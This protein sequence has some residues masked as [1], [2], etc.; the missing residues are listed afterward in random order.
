M[1][2]TLTNLNLSS[3]G[4]SASASNFFCGLARLT[5]MYSFGDNI[6]HVCKL[7]IPFDMFRI[8]TNKSIWCH[9]VI[10][11]KMPNNIVSWSRTM[12]RKTC[13]SDETS[14]A[15][16][17]VISCASILG[18]VG[19]SDRDAVTDCFDNSFKRWSVLGSHVINILRN[20][21]MYS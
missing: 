1:T 6:M 10:L 8:A 11:T 3:N 9:A 2:T 21:A 19:V 12:V 15:V 5:D 20:M 7:R 17:N 4:F 18:V 14:S 16:S 13:L